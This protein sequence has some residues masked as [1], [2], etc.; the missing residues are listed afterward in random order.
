ME[1]L[2][3]AS[4]KGIPVLG[5]DLNND[6]HLI[7]DNQFDVAILSL[8]LQSIIEVENVLLEICRVSNKVILSFPNYAYGPLRKMLYD[9]GRAPKHT[10]V[11]KYEWYNSPNKRYMSI[12]DFEEFCNIKNFNIINS[13][14]LNT[15]QNKFVNEEAVAQ[16]AIERL[17]YL[18]N[19]PLNGNKKR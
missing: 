12:L 18:E 9:E 6:L 17:D 16:Q 5:L 14:Y 4:K 11:L 10:G 1:S 13:K 3:N 15:V 19:M 2:L 8:T 7:N